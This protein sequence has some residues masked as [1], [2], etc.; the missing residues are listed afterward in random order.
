MVPGLYY[1]KIVTLIKEA[2]DSHISKQFHLTPFKLFWTWA[3][4]TGEDSECKHMY[5]ELYNPDVFLVEHNRVQCVPTDDPSCK[6][7]KVVMALMF[8]LD[9]MQLATFRTAKMWPIYMLFGN[10]SKYVRCQPNSGTT[11]HLTYIPPF[12]DLL[13]DDLKDFHHKW[14]TQQRDILAHC[15]CGLMHAVWKFLL[16]NNFIHMYKYGMVLCCQDGIEQHIYPRIFTYSA[17]YPE[18]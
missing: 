15:H 11:K 18:K 8:W 12:P 6:Q 3:L 10:L 1:C 4:P 2:F 13:Q 16:D 14:D 7:E 17:D 9:V 5:S